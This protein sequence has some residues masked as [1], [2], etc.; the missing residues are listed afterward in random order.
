ML[1]IL[2]IPT[3]KKGG[4][5][6]ILRGYEFSKEIRWIRYQEKC[7]NMIALDS[8]TLIKNDKYG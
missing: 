8:K 7:N 1:I 2:L 5:N 3:K 4:H 6:W